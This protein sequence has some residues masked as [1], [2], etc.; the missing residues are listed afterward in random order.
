MPDTQK[1]PNPETTAL[2]VKA[3]TDLCKALQLDP[4]KQVLQIGLHDIE[5]DADGEA[6]S[7]VLGTCSSLAMIP[8]LLRAVTTIMS[9]HKR[10]DNK[11]GGGVVHTNDATGEASVDI[12]KNTDGIPTMGEDFEAELRKLFMAENKPD[13]TP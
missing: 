4:T 2:L 13:T 10:D 12:D 9:S 6:G 8:L 3:T 11:S 7:I 5:P 1:T